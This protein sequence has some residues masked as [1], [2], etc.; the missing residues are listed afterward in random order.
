MKFKY[1]NKS[2]FYNYIITDHSELFIVNRIQMFQK[3]FI[4]NLVPSTIDRMIE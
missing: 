1:Y 4:Y 2:D 3:F